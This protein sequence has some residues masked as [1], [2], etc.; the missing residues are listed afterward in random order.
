MVIAK[1]F[2]A[3]IHHNPMI[4][5]VSDMKTYK[6]MIMTMHKLVMTQ[7]NKPI[8][9][10]NFNKPNKSACIMILFFVQALTVHLYDCLQ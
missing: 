4:L 1:E 9:I 10:A 7:P 6:T 8:C 2:A 3:L 5:K